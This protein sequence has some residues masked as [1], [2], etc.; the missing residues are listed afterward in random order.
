MQLSEDRG[1]WLWVSHSLQPRC[2]LG[3]WDHKAQG[4]DDLLPCSL[5]LL[6]AGLEASLALGQTSALGHVGLC[7]GQLTTQQLASFSK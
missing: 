3:L 6:L 4:G 1:V 5:T 2:W 7:L